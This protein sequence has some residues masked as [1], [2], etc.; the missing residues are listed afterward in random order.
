MIHAIWWKSSASWINLWTQ[1]RTLTNI[2]AQ[3]YYIYRNQ[4]IIM[5]VKKSLKNWHFLFIVPFTASSEI[6]L[7]ITLHLLGHIL[8]EKFFISDS[9]DI[10]VVA[11][12]SSL[13]PAELGWWGQS[14]STGS[15]LGR[16][17]EAEWR[18][19]SMPSL[20]AYGGI[21]MELW[22]TSAW[23]W[24]HGATLVPCVPNVRQLPQETAPPV[25]PSSCC[26][27]CR[28][29]PHLTYIGGYAG[30]GGVKGGAGWTGAPELGFAHDLS[31]DSR[32]YLN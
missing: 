27:P 17:Q 18:G 6:A 30:G 12:L 23:V 9:Q 29:P 1:S 3:H 31:W 32:N 20:F 11:V 28:I 13:C 26:A 22:R 7:V 8:M 21:W 25:G 24:A 5:K 15:W 2:R 16:A 14:H 4:T 19:A 10:P